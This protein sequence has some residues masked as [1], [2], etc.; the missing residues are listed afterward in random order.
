[1][2]NNSIFI[3]RGKELKVLEEAY[4][5]G[6]KEL[7]I[8]Y[9]RRRI[10]KTFLISFFLRRRKG[11]Y[12]TVNFEE[13]DSA[14]R[15]L[16]R[17]LQEQVKLP[18]QPRID[19]FTDLYKLLITVKANLIVID[20]F[21]RLHGTGGVTEL[22]SFW[23][24]LSFEKNIMVVLSGS[25]VGMMEKIGLSYESPLYGRATKILK[26]E[27]LDY[28]SARLFIKGYSEE[29]KVRTYAVFGGTPGYLARLS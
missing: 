7:I 5:S 6:R 22:Q 3:D 26:M 17:Q 8:I 11:I 23:D 16:V 29:D 25:S 20:E 24:R 27:D 13:R 18:Y 10:G 9:G 28:G 2:S 1:M 15:D 12:L 19:S 21:Q 4:N 14:L